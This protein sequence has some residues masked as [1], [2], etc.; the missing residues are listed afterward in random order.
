MPGDSVQ[1]E[2]V[3]PYLYPKVHGSN[4]QPGRYQ[5]RETNPRLGWLWSNL[6]DLR[7]IM[8]CKSD[9][10]LYAQAFEAPRFN[11]QNIP[12]HWVERARAQD[13]FDSCGLRSGRKKCMRLV[14]RNSNVRI[15]IIRRAGCLNR[16]YIWW[17]VRPG[18][19][20][21]WLLSSG[22][23]LLLTVETGL[24]LNATLK[25]RWMRN[26][27]AK[28]CLWMTTEACRRQCRDPT[29]PASAST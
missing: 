25:V 9:Q 2:M 8:C 14:L 22:S 27:G 1:P 15:Y 5:V 3:G 17:Q 28:V 16:Q 26:E 13:R 23:S 20:Q 19:K 4:L 24:A 7:L 18:L 12:K 10:A 11:S 21:F 29:P 6:L